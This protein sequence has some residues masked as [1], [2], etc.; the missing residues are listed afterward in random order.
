MAEE[1]DPI[2]EKLELLSPAEWDVWLLLGEGL[3]TREI[4]EKRFRSIKTAQSHIDAIG[5]K[6]GVSTWLLRAKAA[7]FAMVY[8]KP[9][10]EAKLTKRP[11]SVSP[12]E[13]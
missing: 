8:G 2:L 13:S 6:V 4:A 11:L 10:R 9:E 7:Q 5:D 12:K 3:S 1:V